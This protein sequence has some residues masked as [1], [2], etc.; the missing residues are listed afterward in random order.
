MRLKELLESWIGGLVS[1]GLG[2]AFV[3]YSIEIKPENPYWWIAFIFGLLFQIPLIYFKII[4]I[5]K[6]ELKE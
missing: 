3:Y 4:K 6:E 2:V 1:S 5:V